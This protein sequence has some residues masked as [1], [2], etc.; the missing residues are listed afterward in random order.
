MRMKTNKGYVHVYTGDGKGKTT[1]AL[2][3]ALRA[4]GAGMRVFIGQFVKG[5]CCSEHDAL[6]R[7]GTQVT[8]RRYGSSHFIMGGPS[9]EERR[10]AADGWAEVRAVVESNEYELV[11]LD[12]ACV[13]L[14]LGLLALDEVLALVRRRPQSVEMVMTG[15]GAPQELVDEADLVTEMREIKHYH[16]QGVAA[17][18]GIEK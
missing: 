15:R 1:A 11:I 17:R 5:Q 2:G 18:R 10:L 13:A 7:F 14:G 6:A 4:V 8:V 16:R 9:P 12:E 3:L